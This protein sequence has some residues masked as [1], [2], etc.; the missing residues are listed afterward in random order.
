MPGPVVRRPAAARVHFPFA[1]ERRRVL[2]DEPI[3]ALDRASGQQVRAE[4]QRLHAQG[5]GARRVGV[6]NIVGLH[7]LWHP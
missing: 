7:P 4:L 5:A 3:G 6:M 1:D 2:A